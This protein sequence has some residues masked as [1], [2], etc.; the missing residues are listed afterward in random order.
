MPRINIDIPAHLPFFTTMAVRIGD[1]NYGGHLGNDAVLSIAHEARVRFLASMGYTEH[2]IEG[3]SIIMS[4]AA[5][6]YRGEAHYGDEL[7]IGVGAG[8]FSGSGFDLL[9]RVTREADGKEIALVKTGI[10]FFDYVKKKPQRVP[11]RFR[12]RFEAGKE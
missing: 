9:Y 10:V 12:E 5:V 1:V 2:D 11:A 6:V 7:E 8:N 4:D 3:V